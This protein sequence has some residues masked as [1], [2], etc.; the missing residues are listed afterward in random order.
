M[1]SSPH[2]GF[3]LGTFGGATIIIELSFLI[4]I[5]LFVIMDIER[6]VP[7]RNALL[8]I[9]VILISVLIHE[10]GHALTI[11]AFG[12]GNSM[13]LLGGFGGVTVNRRTSKPWKEI[14]ISIAGPASSL[15]LSLVLQL[16][17]RAAP[18]LH[19]DPMLQE[20]VPLM[21]YANVVWAIFNLFPIYPLDG[22]QVVENMGRFVLSARRATAVSIWSSM[23]LALAV[24]ALALYARS[25][26]AAIIVAMLLMQNWQR[27]QFWRAGS[28]GGDEGSAL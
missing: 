9:P 19:A 28:Q 3:R 23:I 5:G 11:R 16:I 18:A 8:W 6:G 27:W 22:G 26:F 15:V 2:S 12:F 21:I 13:I 4:L 20:L 10:L 1:D 24:L 25:F 14:V 7:T 17:W